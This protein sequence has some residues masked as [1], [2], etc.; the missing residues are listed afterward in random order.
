MRE[1]SE[2]AR[3]AV[4][5]AVGSLAFLLRYLTPGQAAAAAGAAVLANALILPRFAPALF[6]EDERRRPW[7]SGVVIYPVAVLLLV[8]LFRS[9]MEVAAACW[10]IMAAGDSAAG[11]VGRRF[12]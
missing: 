3:K 11:F 5:L 1:H 10:G 9:H 4:H 8:L 12:G 6:R 2:I 7:R